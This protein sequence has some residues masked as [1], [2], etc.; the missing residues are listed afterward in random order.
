VPEGAG[1][2]A[3]LDVDSH[4]CVG[5]EEVELPELNDHVG[6]RARGEVKVVGEAVTGVGSC[7]FCWVNVSGG[8]ARAVSPA[9]DCEPSEDWFEEE[10]K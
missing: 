5:T 3:F 2:A 6:G 9:A 8:G 10:G 1:N 7:G 4:T